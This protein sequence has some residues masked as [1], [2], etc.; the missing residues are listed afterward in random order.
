MTGAGLAAALRAG[1][2]RELGEAVRLRRDLH[3]DP[4]LSGSEHRTAARLAAALGAADAPPI[5]GTG[6]LVRIGPR[7]GPC[8]AVRAELDAL[9]VPEQTGVSWASRTGAMHACGHDVHMAAL[10]ALGR[11]ARRVPGGLPAALL[12]VLQPR[13]E[14]VP[15]GARDIAAAATFAAQQPRAVIGVH[16][17]H[18]LPA[19]MIAAP[20]GT[21][22][23]SSDD[24]EI[25]VDGAAG[26]AGYPHLAADP[27]PALCQA[28]LALQQ[29]VS[30]RTDPTHGAVVSVGT[31]AAGQAPNVIP[32]SATARGTLRALDHGD[33][34]TMRTALREIVQHACL[35]YRCTGSVRIDEGEPALVNDEALAAACWPWLREAGFTVDTSFRSCG[36][37]DF[38]FYARSAPTLMMFVGSGGTASLHHPGFLPHDD[39]VGQVASAMLAGYLGAI[40]L[41]G[42]LPGAEQLPE[43]EASAEREGV[44]GAAGELDPDGL[45]LGVLVHGVGAV[46]AADPGQARAAEGHVRPVYPGPAVA[47]R[48]GPP[49]AREKADARRPDVRR[50]RAAL[51]RAQ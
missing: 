30:R 50:Q 27:V 21:V 35:A 6:R 29:I 51:N 32:P 14:A 40:S 33:R 13:E 9:P 48:G 47:Y 25:R 8:I 42:S 3:A 18:Q 37:D 41:L 36:S 24:F 31:L 39:M 46:L 12:A 49:P 43:A 10:A 34:E 23:A 15:S 19:G 11:A 44:P 5:A 28:V 16:L 38:A 22:N 17:Q 20:A 2:A 1:L 7:R 4:E 45:G 26:H